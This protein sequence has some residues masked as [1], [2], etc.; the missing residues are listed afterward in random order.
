MARLG[1]LQG[2]DMASGAGPFDIIII[3]GGVNGTGIA[4]DAALRGLSVCL[5]EQGDLGGATSSASTK[6]IHGGL[7]YLEFG[8]FRMVRE[9]LM[10]RA[11]LMKLMPGFVTSVKFII[12][13]KK[14]MRP[15]WLIRLGL[16][17][18]DQLGKRFN[19]EGGLP[20][21]RGFSLKGNEFGA[22]LK[23]GFS[24]VGEGEA[25]V[26]AEPMEGAEG[27]DKAGSEVGYGFEY[28]DAVVDDARLVIFNGLE[29]VVEGAV[30]KTYTR[31]VDVTRGDEGW[32]VRTEDGASYK[33][34]GLV[35]A[36][37]PFVNQFIETVMKGFTSLPLRLVRGSHIVVNKLYDHDRAYVLQQGDGRIVF[38]IPYEKY[39]TLIGTTEEDHQQSLDEVKPSAG[40]IKYLMDAVNREFKKQI[41]ETDI[42]WSFAGVRPLSDGDATGKGKTASKMSR[43]Y[44]FAVEENGGFP[45]VHVYGGKITTFRRL[46]ADAVDKLVPYFSGIGPSRTGV[47]VYGAFDK[48]GYDKF[49]KQFHE[50]LVLLPLS[51][52]LRWLKT[53]G[54]RADWF[55]K[56]VMMKR[57]LGEDFGAGLY[58]RE[59]RYLI[60][61]EWARTADDILWRRTKCG[62]HMS[63]EQI[64]H[65]REWMA[66]RADVDFEEKAPPAEESA[67]DEGL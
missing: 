31:V 11:L 26:I 34:R 5:I 4:R 57:H 45:V 52:R 13:F 50:R 53:Y 42:C 63:A 67:L 37:G 30:I 47:V 41:K 18:Y 36:T 8:A 61:R 25:G 20:S 58:E 33:A 51:L 12:P 49:V 29:A 10:E 27:G 66:T 19:V 28:S 38:T 15:K 22:V 9:A 14:T 6:L 62:L 44:Q 43:D 59:V 21:S 48:E 17:I 56:G 23:P 65:F 2:F 1:D 32:V 46:S 24:A 35:N 55:L 40:E 3:G 60:A 39:F 64:A 16:W 54:W 7:R